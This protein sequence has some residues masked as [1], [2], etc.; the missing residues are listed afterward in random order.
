MPLKNLQKKFKTSFFAGHSLPQPTWR[1]ISAIGASGSWAVSGVPGVFFVGC[2]TA[3]A[4]KQNLDENWW[5]ENGKLPRTIRYRQKNVFH[6][7]SGLWAIIEATTLCHY[8][9][10]RVLKRW[11]QWCNASGNHLGEIIYLWIVWFKPLMG[12][13]EVHR[14]VGRMVTLSARERHKITGLWLASAADVSYV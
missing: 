2:P 5:I 8:A 6:L 1:R 9:H 4:N 10:P 12:P 13:L 14:P 7:R 11:C 3:T